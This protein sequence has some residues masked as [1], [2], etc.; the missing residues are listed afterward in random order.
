[1][2]VL[3]LPIDEEPTTI[4]RD[5]GASPFGWLGLLFAISN[6][7]KKMALNFFSLKNSSPHT[8]IG[9]TLLKTQ[10]SLE[11]HINTHLLLLETK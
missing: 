8:H 2:V 6:Y 10:C 5:E 7:T 11:K 1:L 9:N 3:D 4:V